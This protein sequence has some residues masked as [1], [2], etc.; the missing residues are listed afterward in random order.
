MRILRDKNDGDIYEWYRVFPHSI[1]D[2]RFRKYMD[3]DDV[4]SYY[5]RV[6]DEDD[7]REEAI[8]TE[9]Y[10]CMQ[11]WIVDEITTNLMR[12]RMGQST[13][14]GRRI[15]DPL[16]EA[17]GI[18][19]ELQISD[20]NAR[21]AYHEIKELSRGLDISLPSLN[22]LE[23]MSWNCI[24]VNVDAIA[25]HVD[26]L[27]NGITIQINIKPKGGINKNFKPVGTQYI[28]LPHV[29]KTKTRELEGFSFI[30][31]REQCTYNFPSG[32][33][34]TI[35]TSNKQGGVQAIN[36]LMKAVIDPMKK[37]VTTKNLVFK[38]LEK[39]SLEG[40]KGT[41][42]NFVEQ[43]SAAENSPEVGC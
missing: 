37:R 40:I 20:M 23:C 13:L 16:G 39:H 14:N 31:G 27:A 33:S 43:L 30:Y 28:T 34:I 17:T 22:W 35:N 11:R 42:A 36:S 15:V 25:K 6:I 18:P 21:N 38:T 12:L 1:R 2:L 24:E 19:T 3:A 10:L 4:R 41:F 26:D 5:F 32:K 9:P 8:N 7:F 29:D